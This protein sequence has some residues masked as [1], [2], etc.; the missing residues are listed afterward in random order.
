M[1][2][3]CTTRFFALIL[4]AYG[5]TGAA[6]DLTPE[7]PQSCD[8]PADLLARYGPNLFTRGQELILGEAMSEHLEA[9]FRVVDDPEVNSRLQSLGERIAAQLPRPRFDYR[10]ALVDTPTPMAFAF[11]G[12]T[13]YISQTLV[14]MARSE[15]ELAGAI[16]HE[17]ARVAS[18]HQA[19]SMTDLLRRHLDVTELYD[20]NDIRQRYHE[21]IDA[22]IHTRWREDRDAA[23]EKQA[24][25]D[26]VGMYATAKAGY[27]PAAF[28]TLLDRLAGVDRERARGSNGLLETTLPAS[29]RLRKL[30]RET[31]EFW[32]R[33]GAYVDPWR[34]SEFEEF[35]AL[36]LAK[37]GPDH[38]E[39]LEGLVAK[40]Q[41]R[42]PLPT[43]PSEL[44][45]SPDGRYVLALDEQAIYI[46]TREPFEL[47]F[48]VDA[49]TAISAHFTPD[50]R[51]LVW[52]DHELRVE[53]WSLDR[54]RLEVAHELVVSE[55]CLQPLLSPDGTI[56][57]CFTY[58]GAL[59]LRYVLT[60]R[61]FFLE[62]DF[63]SFIRR[64]V[65][66]LV[67]KLARGEPGALLTGFSPDGRYFVAAQPPQRTIAA[68]L[69][70]QQVVSLP[71]SIKDA[72]HGGFTFLD[73]Q[74]IAAVHPRDPRKSG[75]FAFPSGDV[76]AS[77]ALGRQSVAAPTR[78]NFLVVRPAADDPLG[79]VDL[80]TKKLIL[81]GTAPAFDIYDDVFV[82]QHPSGDLR[83]NR[84]ATLGSD[85]EIEVEALASAALPPSRLIG[86]K[87][88]VVSAT[89]ELLAVS[90]PSRGGIWN[91]RTGER[92]TR[93]RGFH[94]AFFDGPT[95]VA[96]F[97][98]FQDTERKIIA[99]TPNGS[100]EGPNLDPHWRQIGDLLLG[101]R[102]RD[103][104]VV[105]E[106]RRVSDLEPS[107]S[108]EVAFDSRH[109][110]MLRWFVTP[111][112]LALVW[113]GQAR[114][115]KRI[116]DAD[117][118]MKA[119]YRTLDDKELVPVVEVVDALTG[120]PT[121][122][123]LMEHVLSSADL[124][125]VH[126]EGDTVVASLTEDRVLLYSLSTGELVGSLF[127][128]E[129]VVSPTARLLGVEKNQTDFVLYRLPSLEEVRRY[130]FG[131]PISY[132]WMNEESD[133]LFVL[134]NL[135]TAYVFELPES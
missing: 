64:P 110:R 20:R 116:V 69:V 13:I 14:G 121:G 118:R 105:I 60:G 85:G 104:D 65:D 51:S 57:A 77:L 11:A 82:G 91:L 130:R 22:V 62:K 43:T 7:T 84:I 44:R 106:A 107:W 33:C 79:V 16:A 89:L 122:R 29:R 93:S 49:P 26:I 55:G 132:A 30:R 112:R 59:S 17:I 48:S 9:S 98:K 101:A 24:Q 46:Y 113:P 66:P 78:G 128:R 15:D 67:T 115:A 3:G 38:E 2:V 23:N 74:R 88:S 73:G 123:V 133:R 126:V 39:A 56:L 76:L 37:A 63:Y 117:P 114:S 129:P 97:P 32:R 90:E 58:E 19:I 45:F 42:E 92:L 119:R 72:L 111:R 8:I 102:A 68:D 75:V 109:D 87:T 5:A 96:D 125:G 35:R 36:A 54:K 18:R 27:D 28:A 124:T 127:G 6:Q 108:R 120:E 131:A 61:E 95:L 99:L 34:A 47:S 81:T 1:D 83:L 40:R 135:Q 52:L 12:G 53:Q 134:T 50:S 70:A 100:V 94:G 4:A 21:Y 41:L 25:A 86:L 71:G 103:D 31:R 10:F 80:V